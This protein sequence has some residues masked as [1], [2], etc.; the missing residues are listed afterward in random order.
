MNDDS[1]FVFYTAFY[2]LVFLESQVTKTGLGLSEYSEYLL[3]SK[4]PSSTRQWFEPPTSCT[5]GGRST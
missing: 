1:K 5:T 3:D 2:R 4:T